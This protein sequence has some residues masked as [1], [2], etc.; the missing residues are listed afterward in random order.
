[1]TG[2]RIVIAAWVCTCLFAGTVLAALADSVANTIAIATSIVLFFVGSGV[3]LVAFGIGI[4][5]SARGDDVAVSNLF[6]LSG[7]A[8]T[9]VKRQFL[10]VL[11]VSIAVVAL[12]ILNRTVAP[13]TWLALMVP[14]GFP[15]L[16]AA[17]HGTFP[18]RVI[19]PKPRR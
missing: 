12:S 1:M 16:W 10:A 13:W 6:F 5:R 15:G 11:L 7:S 3:A 4:V 17:R 8:P 19:A 2:R 18:A 14:I 9:P